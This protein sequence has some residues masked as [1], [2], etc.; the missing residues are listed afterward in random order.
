M[1][2][3]KKGIYLSNEERGKSNNILWGSVYTAGDRAA[4]LFRIVPSNIG[5]FL[6]T[7]HTNC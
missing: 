4:L 2:K 5:Y 6:Y 1:L 3:L 7:Q